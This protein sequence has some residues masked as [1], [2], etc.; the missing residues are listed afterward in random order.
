MK[1]NSPS[2]SFSFS[3]FEE[4]YQSIARTVRRPPQV[5]LTIIY[6]SIKSEEYVYSLDYNLLSFGGP[7]TDSKI[8]EVIMLKKY[9]IEDDKTVYDI[10]SHNV[11]QLLN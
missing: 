5:K 7:M 1:T 4:K 6:L 11:V 8:N 3:S 10:N 9:K 2:S